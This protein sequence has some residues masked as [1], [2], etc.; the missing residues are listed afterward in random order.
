[1]ESTE[2]NFVSALV[3]G[4]RKREVGLVVPAKFSAFTKGKRIATILSDEILKIKTKYT[5][6]EMTFEESKVVKRPFL[7]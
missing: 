4:L 6:F 1:M 5:H 3:V 7:K 2:E